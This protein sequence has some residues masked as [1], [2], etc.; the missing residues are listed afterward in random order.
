MNNRPIFDQHL[1]ERKFRVNIG[2]GIA[3][4]RTL[5]KQGLV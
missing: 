5:K 2:Q 1:R 3:M 4:K